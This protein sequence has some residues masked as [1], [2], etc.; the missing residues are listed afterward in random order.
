MMNDELTFET[1]SNGH[2]DQ[3]STKQ[4]QPGDST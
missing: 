3:L 1:A 4:I 2:H